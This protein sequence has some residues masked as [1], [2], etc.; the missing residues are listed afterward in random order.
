MR[1]PTVPILFAAL[2]LLGTRAFAQSDDEFMVY[3]EDQARQVARRTWPG[4]SL[5][6]GAADR[7]TGMVESDR[8]P[9]ET[10]PFE[11][12]IRMGAPARSRPCPM[13]SC[14]SPMGDASSFPVGRRHGPRIP[15][16]DRRTPGQGT[17]TGQ[18]HFSAAG[19]SGS[20]TRY[21]VGPGRGRDPRRRPPD[22]TDKRVVKATTIQYDDGEDPNLEGEG[23]GELERQEIERVIKQRMGLIRRCYTRELRRNPELQGTVKVRFVIDRDG[24]VKYAAIRGSELGNAIVE[25]CLVEEMQKLRFPLPGGKGTVIV[26]YPFVF[27]GG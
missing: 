20:D 25:D 23:G 15:A 6:P 8:D 9:V 2:A 19:A 5:R 3:D 21:I 22:L 14:S 16:H 11:D 1:N 13:R 4:R 18:G 24:K 12:I 7:D 10:I 17:R 27:K 26:T